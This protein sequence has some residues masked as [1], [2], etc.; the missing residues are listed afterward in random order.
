MLL[1]HLLLMWLLPH[2]QMLLMLLLL[3]EL[4]LQQLSRTHLSLL[5]TLPQPL[6]LSLP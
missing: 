6:S 1:I 3:M 4:L 5:H 2:H